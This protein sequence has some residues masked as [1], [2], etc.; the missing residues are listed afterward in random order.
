M[1][2]NDVREDITCRVFHGDKETFLLA[3]EAS[4]LKYSGQPWYASTLG[5]ILDEVEQPAD[6]KPVVEI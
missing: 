5:T 6:F 1:N 2:T 4:G 3:I